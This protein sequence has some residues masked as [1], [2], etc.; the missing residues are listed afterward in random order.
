[1][2]RQNDDLIFDTGILDDVEMHVEAKVGGK[3]KQS[4]KTD[5]STAGEA[6]TIAGDDSVVPTTNEEITLS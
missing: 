5:D 4:T 1:Q 3:D 2:V 6:V